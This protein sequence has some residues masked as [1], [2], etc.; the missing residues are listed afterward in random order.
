M[1]QG[2]TARKTTLWLLLLSLESQDFV[3]KGVFSNVCKA[4]DKAHPL[5]GRAGSCWNSALGRIWIGSTLKTLQEGV[6]RMTFLNTC[7]RLLSGD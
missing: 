1:G 5:L 7:L 3:G 6:S 4:K 2:S